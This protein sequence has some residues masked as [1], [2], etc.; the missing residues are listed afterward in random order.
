MCFLYKKNSKK[1]LK[2]WMRFHIIIN[3]GNYFLKKIPMLRCLVN[4]Y[5]KQGDGKNEILFRQCN[6]K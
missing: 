2:F 1:D 6:L 5:N 4:N 3:K